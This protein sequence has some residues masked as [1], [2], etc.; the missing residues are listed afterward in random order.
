[1]KSKFILGC[2]RI[3]LKQAWRLGSVHV[4]W[5]YPSDLP[6]FIRSTQEVA[7][8]VL[9]YF[10]LVIRQV[11]NQSLQNIWEGQEVSIFLGD[12]KIRASQTAW[13]Y[14]LQIKW[15]Q[16]QGFCGNLRVTEACPSDLECFC[17]PCSMQ[18]SVWESCV[19]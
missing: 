14:L 1:M 12:Q 10:C 17:I 3:E 16:W 4:E 19:T 7:G 5:W 18:P 9:S 8:T 13:Q 6:R 15:H 11:Y 2:A